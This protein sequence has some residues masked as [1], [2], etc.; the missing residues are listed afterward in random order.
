MRAVVIA[1]AD[2]AELSEH[3]SRRPP[4]FPWSG[5]GHAPDRA[6]G[7]AGLPGAPIPVPP[8]RHAVV[9]HATQRSC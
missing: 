6:P 9:A 1:L 7:L 4:R 5:K 3:D 2:G 8:Q